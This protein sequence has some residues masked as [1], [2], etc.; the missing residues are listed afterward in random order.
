M[1]PYSFGLLSVSWRTLRPNIT[2][3]AEVVATHDNGA[4]ELNPSK[5]ARRNAIIAMTANTYCIIR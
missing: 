2:D 4:R 1:G 5:Q 3:A